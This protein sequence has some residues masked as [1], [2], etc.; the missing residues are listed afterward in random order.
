MATAGET[1]LR[2]N[3]LG[4]L[5]RLRRL[6]SGRM[7]L[8]MEK[9]AGRT[10]MLSQ[11]GSILAEAGSQEK[12]AT[13]IKRVIAKGKVL[14]E[15]AAKLSAAP[16]TSSHHEGLV[17]KRGVV[18]T[19]KIAAVPVKALQGAAKAV[20]APPKIRVKAFTPKTVGVPHPAEHTPRQISQALGG[21]PDEG[22]M[23]LTAHEAREILKE[24]IAMTPFAKAIARRKVGGPT[25]TGLILRRSGPQAGSFSV[26][27]PRLPGS[28]GGVA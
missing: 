8:A 16:P 2:Q 12:P 25:D 4:L 6:G 10:P 11:L 17:R 21:N 7:K 9:E 24:A 22:W 19:P 15:T 3:M 13:I 20:T 23:K 14:P 26:R 27:Q 18:D 1:F 28:V 5:N